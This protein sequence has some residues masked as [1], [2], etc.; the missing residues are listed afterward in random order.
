MREIIDHRFTKEGE[1]RLQRRAEGVY[2]LVYNGVFLMASSNDHS[3][4]VLARKALQR[5]KPKSAEYEVLIGGLGMGFTLREV[6]TC[7][8]VS[9]A[10]VIE[11]E[12]AIIDWNRTFLFNL[13]G[14]ALND[15]RTVLVHG[16]LYS[17]F[18]DTREHFDAVLMDVDNGPNWLVLGRNKRLYTRKTLQK[19]KEILAPN[20]VLAT[21]SAQRDERYLRKMGSVFP[22]TE[23]TRVEETVPKKGESFIYVGRVGP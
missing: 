10:V 3:E 14:R 16:D 17:F 20:G 8:G 22:Q 7:P 9:R 21:W 13:N 5:L 2:E 1:I 15:P 11:I 12:K 18:Y 4:K 6:L 19:I 23:E